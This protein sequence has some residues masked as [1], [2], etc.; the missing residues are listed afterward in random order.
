MTTGNSEKILFAASIRMALRCMIGILMLGCFMQDSGAAQARTITI[1]VLAHRPKPEV[2]AK[3]QPTA[4]Y[5]SQRIPGYRFVIVPFTYGETGQVLKD[6]EAGF[7]ITNPS[8]YVLLSQQFGL[9]RVATL[10]E[11]ERGHELPVFGGTILA[12]SGRADL[13]AL[14]D[15]KGRT[16]ASPD[17]KSLGGYQVQAAALLEAGITLPQDARLLFTDM[18]H[19]KAIIAVLEGSADAAFVRT[20]VLE[21]MISSGT[22]TAGRLKVLNRQEQQGFPFALSTALYPE[23][24][25]AVMPGVDAALAKTVTITLLSMQSDQPALVAGKY[26]GWAIPADYE[27]VRRLLENLHLPPYAKAADFSLG[28]IYRKHR[29]AV[30]CGAAMLALLMLLLVKL[31]AANQ[32]LEQEIGIRERQAKQ[33]EAL[34]RDLEQEVASETGLRYKSEQIVVQQSKLAAMGEMLG[35]IAHQWRQPLNALGLIVQNLKDAHDHGELN[36]EYLERTVQKSMAQIQHMSTTID[37]FR[38]FFQPDKEKTDFDAMRA[39]GNVLALFSAQ[40]AANDI[41]YRLACRTH[42]KVFDNEA[43][44]VPCPEKMVTGYRNEFEHVILN[45]INNAREAVLERREQGQP[46]R[47]ELTFEFSCEDNKVILRVSDN[48]GGIQPPALGRIFE[49]YFTTKGPSK[50]TGLG[51]YMSKVIIEDHMHG[52]IRAEQS[53]QGAVFILELARSEKRSTV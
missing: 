43:D 9:T 6:R 23:W 53:G 24:P 34:T 48:G 1:A 40:L 19:D 50:G 4:D 38:N 16:I 11:E 28:D 31:R 46:V 30:I 3:W 42:N 27:S 32:R 18:P 49:P 44:I 26:H 25:F 33:L 2:L 17:A 37:D 13:A 15:L 5:L 14:R 7:V 45:L 41:G 36:K 8:H 51:L 39:V 52:A 35:A 47:G 10:I 12:A 20:G 22:V 29:V 21:G